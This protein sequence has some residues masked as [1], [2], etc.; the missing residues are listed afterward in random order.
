MSPVRILQL[1]M[2]SISAKKRIRSGAAVHARVQIGHRARGFN[3]GVNQPA[4]PDAQCR[5]IGGEQLR[6]GDQREVGFQLA[7]LL[8]T[9]SA[10]ASPPTSSSPSNMNSHV[11]RQLAAAALKSDSNAFTCIQSWPLSSTA[12]RA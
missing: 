9:Y 3:F 8:R 12:P 2:I 5:K 11:D 10:I 6:V 4:Q 1:A 7:G